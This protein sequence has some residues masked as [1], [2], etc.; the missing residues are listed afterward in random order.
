MNEK[1][2]T[3]TNKAANGAKRPQ[4]A[5][6]IEQVHKMYLKDLYAQLAR[7]LEDNGRSGVTVNHLVMP[8]GQK[9]KPTTDH[10]I[11]QLFY[12]ESDD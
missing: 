3:A 12:E 4:E 2:D 10:S 1:T 9:G 7:F 6:P 11:V 5:S 8:K